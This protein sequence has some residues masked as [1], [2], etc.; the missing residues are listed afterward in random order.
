MRGRDLV[1]AAR[2]AAALGD[3]TLRVGTDQNL[4]LTGVAD[5]VIDDLLGEDLLK[6]YSPDA[7]PFTRGVV[8]CTGNEFCRYAITET[9]QR[10]VQLAARLDERLAGAGGR[11]RGDREPIRIHLSGCSASCAQPQ[12]ADIGLRGAVHKSTTAL[13]EAYDLGLGGALGPEAGFVDWVEGAVP[14]RQLEDA[15]VRVVL[16]YEAERVE[17][18]SFTTWARAASNDRLRQIVN[19]EDV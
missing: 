1:E 5:H 8:A 3:G 4:I 13:E 14:A 11:A 10:A 15:I 9:K 2:L 16:A 17:S 6:T 19:G 12:I 18:Q 7:G